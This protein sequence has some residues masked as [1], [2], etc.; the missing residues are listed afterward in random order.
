MTAIHRGNKSGNQLIASNLYELSENFSDAIRNSTHTIYGAIHR[1]QCGPSSKAA[2]KMAG[3]VRLGTFHEEEK[4]LTTQVTGL[5]NLDET[6]WRDLVGTASHS[7]PYTSVHVR[8]H[9]IRTHTT[10]LCNYN[11]KHILIVACK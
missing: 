5:H 7:N 4:E 9:R 2:S 1:H 10:H 8:V 6:G 3:Y 11:L